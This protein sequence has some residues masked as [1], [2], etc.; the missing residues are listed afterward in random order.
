MPK[1]YINEFVGISN[2]LETLPLAFAIR[3]AYGHDIILDWHEL[4]SFSV[5]GTRRGKVRALT[6]L[7][8]V[9]VRNCDEE[10]FGRLAG[11]KIILRSLDG[12]SELLDPIYLDVARKVRLNPSLAT[13]IRS[14]FGRTSGRP[15]VGVHIRHGDF[16]VVDPDRYEN[17]ATEWPAVPLW[18]YERAMAAIQ[19]RQKDTVFF[20]AGTGDP[21]TYTELHRNFDV[22]TLDVVSHYDYKGPDHD[23][24]VNP[25]ADLFALAC[26]PLMLAT[27][28]SGYSHWAANA[29]GGPTDCIVPLPGATRD[30]PFMGVLRIYGSRLPR[31]RAAGRTGS[32]VVPIDQ[33]LEG[34]DLG[35]G[36]DTGWL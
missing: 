10:M 29:L 5:E 35:R 11:R 23:S 31:W 9:R 30:E 2:R 8:A 12:P 19:A 1:L 24:R 4:D 28:I 32:D 25:V 33:R 34:V 13:Q 7:G 22:A 17:T 21:D 6:K 20:L 15:V 16:Q 27:P 18:W 3:Q 36:A 14:F 26:C